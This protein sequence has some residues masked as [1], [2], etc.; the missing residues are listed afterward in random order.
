MILLD[1][2][3]SIIELLKEVQAEIHNLN[4]S[5]KAKPWYEYASAIGSLLIAFFTQ[6]YFF[7]RTEKKERKKEIGKLYSDFSST[8]KQYSLKFV[9]LNALLIELTVNQ[10]LLNQRVKIENISPDILKENADRVEDF[11]SKVG[12]IE[13]LFLELKY[14]SLKSLYEIQYLCNHSTLEALIDNYERVTVFHL[15]LDKKIDQK[16]LLNPHT[17]Q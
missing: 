8:S 7:S 11:T 1:S 17:S 5:I 16:E 3:N 9:E 15:G 10:Q 6:K 13:K 2:T 12:Q 14:N 4:I